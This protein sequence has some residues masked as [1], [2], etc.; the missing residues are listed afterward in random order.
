MRRDDDREESCAMR[1]LEALRR[2][3]FRRP[4]RAEK[5][6]LQRC[7]GDPAHAERLIRHELA[8]RPQLSRVAASKSAL[9]R[10]ARDR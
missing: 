4:S 8:R 10:W 2:W 7:Y 3:L 9:E 1:F 5:Q 6:L